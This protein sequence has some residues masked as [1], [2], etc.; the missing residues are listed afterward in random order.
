MWQLSSGL[1]QHYPPFNGGEQTLAFRPTI[2]RHCEE[3][4]DEAIERE[5]VGW[6]KAQSAVPTVHQRSRA[7]WWARFRFAHPTDSSQAATHTRHA[8]IARRAVFSCAVG[9]ITTILPRVSHPHEGRFAIVTDVG[10]GMRW[11]QR[12]QKTND[13]VADGEVVWSWRPKVGAKFAAIDPQATVATKPGHRGD[14]V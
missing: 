1:A 6:A 8:R 14:H 3:Q 4:R 5:F 11:T 7:K 10:R 13:V 12:R 2:L 9:Q